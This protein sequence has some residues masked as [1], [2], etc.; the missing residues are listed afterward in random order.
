ME[1]GRFVSV[2]FI[3]VAIGLLIAVALHSCIGA[4]VRK[5][6]DTSHID[7]SLSL[8]ASAVTIFI[9]GMCACAIHFVEWSPDLTTI[10]GRS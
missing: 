7:H 4:S 8:S 2:S 9:G 3:V 1:A 10:T 6:A 5:E